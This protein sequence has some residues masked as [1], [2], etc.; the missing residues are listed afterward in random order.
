M[1]RVSVHP[2]PKAQASAG[3]GR[4]D[5]TSH[6]SF[7]CASDHAFDEV[8]LQHEVDDQHGDHREMSAAAAAAPRS[9]PEL[10]KNV[11]IAGAIVR[12]SGDRMRK[13]PKAYSFH[14]A[15]PVRITTVAVTGLSRGTTTWNRMRTGP[16][17]STDAASSIETGNPA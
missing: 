2:L 8:S 1:A 9:L 13:M 3:A 16:A 17:P 11:P 5:T 14:T 15:T 4:S 6:S 7:L 12:I 10:A